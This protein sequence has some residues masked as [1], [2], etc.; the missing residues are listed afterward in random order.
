MEKTI[1]AVQSKLHSSKKPSEFENPFP[2]SVSLVALKRQLCHKLQTSLEVDVLLSHYFAY[3]Q[4]SA[5]IQGLV[6][7]SAANKLTFQLGCSTCFHHRQD[8]HA[9][10]DYVGELTLYADTAFE[11]N[12]RQKL[13]KLSSLLVYPLRNAL[14]YRQLKFSA[15]TDFLTGVG[16]RSALDTALNRE[17]EL[18]QR[19][20]HALSVLML[21]LDHFKKINDQYGHAFGDQVLK[22]FVHQVQTVA[23]TTDSIFRYGGEEFTII[24]S[25]TQLNGALVIAERIRQAVQNL[26]FYAVNGSA[27]PVTVSIGAAT[28]IPNESIEELLERADECLYLAKSQGRNRCLAYPDPSKPSSLTLSNSAARLTQN[29]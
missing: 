26:Q 28:L 7:N 13:N 6:Y 10:C 29:A 17:F 4:N 5:G 1:F 8:L 20:Q 22:R 14:A 11:K 9:E 16:N 15:Q 19:H 24:L 21:D 12:S 23:R 18:A 27:V 3:L 2:G 25:N